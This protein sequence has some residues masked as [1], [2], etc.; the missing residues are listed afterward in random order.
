MYRI[1]CKDTAFSFFFLQ[2]IAKNFSNKSKNFNQKLVNS[3]NKTAD[4]TYYFFRFIFF[5]NVSNSVNIKTGFIFSASLKHLM[6]T[7]LSE[8]DR[9]FE[10]TKVVTLQHSEGRAAS[11]CV[12]KKQECLWMKREKTG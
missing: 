8:S 3:Y 1:F 11:F 7:Q 9:K 4:L 5:K 10:T 12:Q 6:R 2:N